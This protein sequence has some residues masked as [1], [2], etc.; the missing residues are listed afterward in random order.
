MNGGAIREGGRAAALNEERQHKEGVRRG[1]EWLRG[2]EEK[3]RRLRGGV[4]AWRSGRA[5]R[6]CDVV[7]WPCSAGVKRLPGGVVAWRSGRARRTCGAGMVQ[8]PCGA[9]VVRWSCSVRCYCGAVWW[10]GN[11]ERRE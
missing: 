2:G 5:R 10:L 7:R 6:T 1:K 9:G 8:W 3:V 11:E 4:V